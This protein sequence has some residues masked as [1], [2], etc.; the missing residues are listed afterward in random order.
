M[1]IAGSEWRMIKIT[2][3]IDSSIIFF[4]LYC[5]CSDLI[6]DLSA[7]L[8]TTTYS[9]RLKKIVAMRIVLVKLSQL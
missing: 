9:L 3:L 2:Q 6:D 1:M 8:D 5:S 4:A 7:G